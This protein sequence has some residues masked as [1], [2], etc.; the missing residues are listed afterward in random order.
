MMISKHLLDNADSIAVCSHDLPVF[1]VSSSIIVPTA[2][3]S[4]YGGVMVNEDGVL[5]RFSK[6][7]YKN[8]RPAGYCRNNQVTGRSHNRLDTLL[9]RYQAIGSAPVRC[10]AGTDSC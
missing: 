6:A 5:Q 4:E 10:P 8:D 3:Y 7:V 9:A 1:T 2:S